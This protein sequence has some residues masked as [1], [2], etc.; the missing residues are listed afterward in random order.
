MQVRRA[1]PDEADLLTELC[2]RSKAS[3]GY[4]D[5]FM[6]ACRAELTVTPALM[7][8]CEFWVADDAG[9]CGCVGLLVGADGRSGE[10]HAFFIDPARK[11][12]GIGRRLWDALAARARER[13]LAELQLDADPFAVP[14]YEALGF[15]T[16]GAAPS[17][18][19]PGRRI[20]RMRFELSPNRPA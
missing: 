9:V 6:A 18:S 12:Q 7:A 10:V 16:T 5:A 20:P 11:R 15:V 8:E 3:N 17:G 1:R 2:L 14:F 13:G 4:D 19:I